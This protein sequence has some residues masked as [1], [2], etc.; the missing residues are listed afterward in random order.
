MPSPPTRT[1]I[2]RVHIAG[3]Q[4]QVDLKRVSEVLAGKLQR[5][6]PKSL[7]DVW[8]TTSRRT[9]KSIG[10]GAVHEYQ[11]VAAL[12]TSGVSIVHGC[13]S[14]IMSNRAA[15]CRWKRSHALRCC[16]QS[17]EA[18]TMKEDRVIAACDACSMR[19]GSCTSP[20]P[21]LWCSTHGCWCRP[22]ALTASP[23]AASAMRCFR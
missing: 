14:F 11:I 21:T 19:R 12:M 23:M 6:P 4:A 16:V 8:C 3:G 2:S 22:L 17:Q 13:D 20:Q 1:D 15:R 5:V 18:S 10:V 7:Q 9:M